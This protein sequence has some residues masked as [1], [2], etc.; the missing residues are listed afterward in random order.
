M[1]FSLYLE[2]L[3]TTMNQLQ[4]MCLSEADILNIEIN[5]VILW[6]SM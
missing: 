5:V 4:M 6:S 1:C 3:A 2:S